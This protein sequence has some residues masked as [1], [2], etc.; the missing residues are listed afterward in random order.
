MAK[1]VCLATGGTAGHI[2]PALS[3]AK[4]MQSQHIPF[5]VGVGIKNNPYF[6]DL[7]CKIC[8][9]KGA[10]FSKGFFHGVKSIV[11]GTIKS[12]CFLRQ[13][14]ITKVIGFGSFHSLPAILAAKCLG[15]DVYLYESNIKAG[16]ANVFFSLF[17][18]KTFTLFNECYGI[19]GA[20]ECIGT[21]LAP[22]KKCLKKDLYYQKYGLDKDKK[23]L[24]IAGGS[25]GSITINTF[26]KKIIPFMPK[27][28]QFIH[29]VGRD[30]D[31]QKYR[32]VYKD[33]GVFLASYADSI[34]EMYAMADCALLRSGANTVAECIQYGVA[35]LFVPFKRAVL[36]HQEHNARYMQDIIQGASM[37]PE[38]TFCPHRASGL[39]TNEKLNALRRKNLAAAR[40]K[41]LTRGC[42]IKGMGL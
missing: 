7:G 37:M 10:N 41:N 23:T 38:D 30:E 39:L 17:A 25:L 19:R 11:L 36:N 33:R 13:N 32:Q 16:R 9:T 3:L 34:H 35:A 15:L 6:Q 12:F 24:L 29:L 40:Q 21:S 20:K 22:R 18:K 4:S 2:Y 1:R 14:N 31:P 26:A 8:S 5:F 28:F 42:I 27:D